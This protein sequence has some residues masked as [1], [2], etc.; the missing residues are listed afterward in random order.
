MSAPLVRAS[1]TLPNEQG[2]HARPSAMIVRTANRFQAV[3][4][5]RVGER[6]A[7]CK[8]IMEVLMLASPRGTL[9]AFEASGM[10]A[11][12]AVQALTTLVGSGFGE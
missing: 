2:L 4:T 12:A 3:V 5:M 10:D 9:L 11:D 8:S 7:D 1:V 6:S